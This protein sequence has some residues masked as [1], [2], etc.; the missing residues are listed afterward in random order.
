VKE[1]ADR[2]RNGLSKEEAEEAIR[3]LDKIEEQLLA[4]DLS[5]KGRKTTSKYLQH[6]MG[7]LETYQQRL[8]SYT[9]NF[10]RAVKN[11]RLLRD[12][13]WRVLAGL[14]LTK[15]QMVWSSRGEGDFEL[16][17]ILN[18]PAGCLVLQGA[19]SAIVAA[20]RAL[21]AEHASF[22]ANPSPQQFEDLRP[23]AIDVSD[24][25]KFAWGQVKLIQSVL[26]GRLT[27]S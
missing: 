8:L 20:T 4:L 7:A 14:T 9:E 6:V 5:P 18:P 16:S 19:L 21:N 10:E 23:M 17:V 15:M 1:E 11:P 27:Q 3:A 2:G 24:K 12:P 26:D 22:M 25:L 13:K